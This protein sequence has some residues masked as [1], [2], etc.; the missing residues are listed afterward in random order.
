[1]SGL[2]FASKEGVHLNALPL[3]FPVPSFDCHVITPAQDDVCGRMHSKTSYV[4]RMCLECCDL[5]VGIVIEHAYLEVVGTCDEPALASDES[6]A[7]HWDLRDFESFYQ[8]T[9]LMVVYVKR[10]IIETS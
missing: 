1:M 8:C 5:L 2:E 4:V 10:A 3:L 6:T 9:C 7:P